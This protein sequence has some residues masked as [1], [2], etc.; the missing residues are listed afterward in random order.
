M[1]TRNKRTGIVLIVIFLAIALSAIPVQAKATIEIEN[2]YSTFEGSIEL[3]SGEVV[4]LTGHSH[5]L[6]RSVY[7]NTD[8]WHV[9]YHTNVQG[10]SGIGSI[11]GDTY[12]GT[13][14]TQGT[15]NFHADP[16]GKIVKTIVNNVRLI[17]RGGTGESYMLHV[18][19]HITV[20][21]NGTITS[22]HYNMRVT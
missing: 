3:P 20:N 4:N 5:N 18:E 11:T 19:T 6:H 22:S 21:P 13:G 1:K 9:K 15:L 10:V 2:S 14:V 16:N 8:G 12:S 7:D 17:N